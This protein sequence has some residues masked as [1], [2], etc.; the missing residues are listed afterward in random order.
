MTGAEFTARYRLREQINDGSVASFRAIDARGSRVFVHVF[1]DTAAPDF[2]AATLDSAGTALVREVLDVEAIKV[3]VTGEIEG[4]STFEAWT[5]DRQR[6]EAGEP[7]AYTRIFRV[8]PSEPEPE[9]IAAGSSATPT[10]YP[11]ASPPPA[12][13]VSAPEPRFVAPTPPEPGEYTRLFGVASDASSQSAPS[14]PSGP[15]PVEHS[16]YSRIMRPSEPIASPPQASGGNPRGPS[17]PARPEAPAPPPDPVRYQASPSP[18][19]PVTP[20]RQQAQPPEPTT[21]AYTMFM[22]TSGAAGP[23]LEAPAP[24]QATPPPRAREPLEPEVYGDNYAHRLR[25]AG[26]EATPHNLSAPPDAPRLD[27]SLYQSP[28]PSEPGSY[29]MIIG[30]GSRPGPAPAF[31]PPMGYPPPPPPPPAPQSPPPA[32]AKSKTLLVVMLVL[33][34]SLLAALMLVLFLRPGG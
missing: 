29:T 15:S 14:P 25:A 17:A 27:P 3:V 1:R 20:L 18:P 6:K 26:P 8:A 34:L 22:R 24:R 13:P 5:A 12:A 28:A 30:G 21:G 19:P 2:D 9:T 11:P 7:G 10:P 23:P 16:T 31:E 32:K 4:F 33:I